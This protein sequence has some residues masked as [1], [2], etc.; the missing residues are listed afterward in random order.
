MTE[1]LKSIRG[2]GGKSD[3]SGSNTPS[4]SPNTLRATARAAVLDL[5]CEGPIEGPVSPGDLTWV[6]LDGVPL[7]NKNL[8]YNFKN[9]SVIW[10]LGTQTQSLIK[11]FPDVESAFSVNTQVL[12]STPIIRTV[13]DPNATAVRVTLGIPVL[14]SIDTS[15]GNISGTHVDYAIDLQ[16]NGGGYS[17][18]YL[19]GVSGKTTT[20]F[21]FGIRIELTGTPPWD[22]RVRRITPDNGS[23]TLNNATYWDSYTVIYDESYTYPN[24]AMVGVNVDATQF[25]NVPS[26]AY[27]LRLLKVQ[28]PTNYDPIN[29][30]YTGVWDGTFKIAWTDN[31]AW[32]FYDMATNARYGAGKRITPAMM[33]KWGLYTISQYCDGFLP[34]G[35]AKRA[36]V[37]TGAISLT[38]SSTTQ[39]YTRTTGSF[40]TDGFA[41]GDE[42]G[43]TG[44][45]NAVNNGRGVLTAVSALVL[46]VDNYQKALITEGP[47]AGVVIQT[48]A[49][50]EP[51][52]T[53]NAYFQTQADAFRV[54]ANLASVFRGML[55]W[56][57]VLS[58]VQDSP[59]TAAAIF[60]KANIRNGRFTYMGSSIQVRHTVCLV[61]WND[62]TDAYLPKVE[63]VEDKAGITRYGI[64]SIQIVAIGCTSQSQAR[65]VGLWALISERTE[66]EMVQFQTGLEGVAGTA[67]V[68]GE[69]IKIQDSDRAGRI[70]GGRVISATTSQIT[71][72]RDVTIE[73]GKTYT[74][75][76]MMPDGTLQEH[77]V[78]TPNS[79]TSTLTV[80]PAYT[81][82]PQ[83]MAMWTLSANDLTPQSFRVVGIAEKMDQATLYYEITAVAHNDSKFATVELG[84]PLVPA[85]ISS[86][87]FNAAPTGLVIGEELYLKSGTLYSKLTMTWAQPVGATSYLIE[88]RANNG[89]WQ[90]LPPDL[91]NYAE[92]FDVV[93]GAY[94]VRVQ[95]VYQTGVS[96]AVTGSYTVLGKNAPPTNVSNFAA[97]WSA[98]GLTL[99]WSAIPDLDL[100]HYEIR[101]GASWAAGTPIEGVQTAGT[102]TAV[103]ATSYQWR[104]PTLPPP[105]LWIAA[106]DTTGHYSTAP[107]TITPTN[108]SSTFSVLTFSI[109]TTRP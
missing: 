83:N 87:P 36:T 40:V 4:E 45:V 13:T 49:P 94:D 72:D 47:V 48:Q 79:T 14:S 105:Q 6:Y 50:T 22:I 1:K 91:H 96:P 2:A 46:T 76:C 92:V 8:S 3:G 9:I 58:V 64:R 63:Y 100:S 77:P 73:L 75:L 89:Q 25:S 101:Q 34:T 18:V 24:S 103:S 41:V 57:S 66:T 85:K 52:F 70:M 37:T 53:C 55:Y 44:F 5:V 95:A 108:P 67:L 26:R 16:A 30:T 97:T 78:I 84:A 11:G 106:L 17:Q 90:K 71:L 99:S 81:L 54:L 56:L 82:A 98:Q 109:S 86:L 102:G 74:L 88:Y 107:A 15:S 23:S 31:P 27:D 19:S 104:V 42:V 43:I 12:N 21:E 69:I 62:P 28:V 51:R 20:L 59:A 61:T 10:N 35:R 33:D 7:Q 93:L 38:T 60:N 39:T 29:R 65:R 68:P 80:S 32:C